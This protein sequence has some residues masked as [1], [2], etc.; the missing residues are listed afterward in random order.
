MYQ[1]VATHQSA[2]GQEMPVNTKPALELASPGRGGVTGCQRPPESCSINGMLPL[3][4]DKV[5][6]T[7]TQLP[8]AGQETAANEGR[9]SGRDTSV[10]AAGVQ[11]PSASVSVR[12]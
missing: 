4:L 10:T 2:T 7:A 11:V 1:P 5:D 3:V 12:P 6:P 9:V 8:R